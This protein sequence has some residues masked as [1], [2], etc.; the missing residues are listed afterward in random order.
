[1]ISVSSLVEYL[2]PDELAKKSDLVLTGSVKEILPARWN[3]PDE[4]SQ[5]MQWRALARTR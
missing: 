2:R 3:T 5:K 4:S 1:M